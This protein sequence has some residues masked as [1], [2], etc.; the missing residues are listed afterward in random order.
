MLEIWNLAGHYCRLASLVLHT[1]ESVIW[2]L[3]LIALIRLF[4]GNDKLFRFALAF[5]P[6]YLWLQRLCRISL[7]VIIIWELIAIYQA[8]PIYVTDT[9]IWVLGIVSVIWFF[10]FVWMFWWLIDAA[11]LIIL[12]II[13]TI[14][15]FFSWMW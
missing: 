2:P 8:L 6:R 12:L 3:L 5:A 13:G 7:M 10:V 4:W 15:R 11:Y 14:R 1:N 9:N